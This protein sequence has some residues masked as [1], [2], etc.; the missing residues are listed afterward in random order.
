MHRDRQ[1]EPARIVELRL[2][3]LRLDRA[4]AE[5]P[6]PGH[7]ERNEALVG[8]AL[9]VAGEALDRPLVGRLGVG[10]ALRPAAGMAGAD[11]DLGE[12]ADVGLG[13]AGAAHVVTPGVNEGHPGID[14]LRGG[15]PRALKDVVSVHLLAEARDGREVAFLRLV[16]GEAA[17]ERVPHVPMGL[18]QARHDDHA[19]AVDPLP[20]AL[21]VLA[22]RDDLAVPDVDRPARDIAKRAVH[23]HHKGITDSELAARR[24]L[25]RP[26]IAV[27]GLSQ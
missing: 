5:L 25:R 11:A 4:A 19:G 14:R 22:D 15:E 24:Q 7:A 6:A 17:K 12:R 3:D 26:A 27:P 10:Q 16:A 18:D 20:A 1:P 23:G 2:I 21:H 8:P 9:P 13:M